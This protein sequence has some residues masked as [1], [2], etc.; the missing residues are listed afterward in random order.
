M[1]VFFL[2]A[3]LIIALFN[4]KRIGRYLYPIKYEEY[5]YKYSQQ[6]NVEPLLVASIIKAESNYFK[7]AK[8]HKGA[9]GLMQI[10]PMTGKWAAE[11]IGINGYSED[12]LYDHGVNIMIGCWYLDRLGKQFNDLNLVISAY[13]AGSGNV[14]K[15]LRNEEYSIDGKALIKIPFKETEQYVEKVLR[16]YQIY[17]KLYE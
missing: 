7:N 6:Y 9:I 3:L 2:I 10:I 14:S 1:L 12:L 5:I 15:W 4:I 8:S 16:N 11:E 13:N 17:R